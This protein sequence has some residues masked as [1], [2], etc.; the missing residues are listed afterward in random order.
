VAF[1]SLDCARAVSASLQEQPVSGSV[2]ASCQSSTRPTCSNRNGLADHIRSHRSSAALRHREQPRQL[3]RRSSLD[4]DQT[5]SCEGIA[6]PSRA[7]LHSSDF[8]DPSE[9]TVY[10][11]F[12]DEVEA[13]A[14]VLELLSLSTEVRKW[15]ASDGNVLD[16]GIEG[17]TRAIEVCRKLALEE[18]DS[19]AFPDGHSPEDSPA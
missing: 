16:L 12:P 3:Q 8:D 1:S 7:P 4:R 11:P 15:L 10:K 6:D 9:Q 19:A 18:G 2:S 13:V 14:F 17:A 5:P